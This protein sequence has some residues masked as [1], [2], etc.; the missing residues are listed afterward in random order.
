MIDV[1]VHHVLLTYD[2]AGKKTTTVTRYEVRECREDDF[3]TDY[4]KD[5]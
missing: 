2:E 4:E 3:Q 1:Y 5:Y